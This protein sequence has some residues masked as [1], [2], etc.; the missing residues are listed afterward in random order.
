MSVNYIQGQILA[1]T[2]ER[3]GINLTIANANVGIG[4]APSA[5]LD[6]YGN[7]LVGNVLISNIGTISA[8][9]NITSGNLLT[10][11]VSATGNILTGNIVIPS[12]GNILVGNVNINNLA[13]PQANTDAA[14]KLYVDQSV[15]NVATTN[16]TLN[17][18]GSTT[19][20]T[21]N[22]STTTAAA[23]IMLNGIVQVPATAYNMSPNPSTSLVFNEAP[24]L[25]DVIDVR[26]L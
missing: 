26:F 7:L 11:T 16:Q 22:R 4:H 2:L 19:T 25:G 24:A 15:S 5:C 3:N 13:Y 1:S 14:T 23:L 9:G 12:T 17:G 10:G 8:T 18:D 20:F 21:L 6:V